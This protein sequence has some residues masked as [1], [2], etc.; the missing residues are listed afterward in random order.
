MTGAKKTPQIC[1]TSLIV[2]TNLAVSLTVAWTAIVK[3]RARPDH[4]P[5]S[6]RSH[7]QGHNLTMGLD[8]KKPKSKAMAP[9]LGANL[10]LSRT[11]NAGQTPASQE[12]NV[13]AV[14]QAH[15]LPQPKKRKRN[16]PPVPPVS[17]DF[18]PS[19]PA[20]HPRATPAVDRRPTPATPA[21]PT[22]HHP[23]CYPPL[24]IRPA[25]VTPPRSPWTR[26]APTN[27]SPSPMAATQ[28]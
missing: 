26:P 14:Q 13:G 5:R 6:P 15:S 1:I 21:T 25:L 17:N 24:S 12:D 27:S 23:P 28:T 20:R 9:Q 19:P 2:I 16:T 22:H 8:T 4:G 7:F 18:S 11:T 10:Q 3:L